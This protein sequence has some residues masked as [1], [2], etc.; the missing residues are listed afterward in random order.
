MPYRIKKVMSVLQME[1]LFPVTVHVKAI[2]E[3]LLGKNLQRHFTLHMVYSQ[4]TDPHCTGRSDSC[5]GSPGSRTRRVGGSDEVMGTGRSCHWEHTSGSSRHIVCWWDT[6][7][8][9]I[10]AII[11]YYKVN[12][13][14]F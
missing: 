13:L 7:L 4:H 11:V 6:W 14:E 12:M 1:I 10:T 2:G 9:A 5:S 8:S 3:K